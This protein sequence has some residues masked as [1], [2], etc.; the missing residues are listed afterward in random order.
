MNEHYVP[1][2][3]VRAVGCKSHDISDLGAP[4]AMRE[5]LEE[6]RGFSHLSTFLHAD[7]DDT[8][9]FGGGRPLNCW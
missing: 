7:T 5:V 3:R 1:T 2:V 8:C 6:Q 4:G 9:D